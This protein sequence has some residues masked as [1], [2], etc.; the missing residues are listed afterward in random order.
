MCMEDPLQILNF[1]CYFPL[2]RKKCIK[3]NAE[4]HS[5]TTF[6]LFIKENALYAEISSENIRSPKAAIIK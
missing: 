1:D 6:C 3:Q 4:S 5:S 2:I